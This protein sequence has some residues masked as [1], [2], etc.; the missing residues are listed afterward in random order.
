[1]KV[2]ITGISGFAGNFMYDFLTNIKDIDIYGMY[3]D[4]NRKNNIQKKFDKAKLWEIDMIN[5]TQ[6]LDNILKEV[7]PDIIMHFAAYVTVIGSFKNPGPIFQTNLIGTVNLLESVRKIIPE[8]KVLITGSAEEYGKVPNDKLP[9]KEEYSLNPV[10]PYALSKKFQEDIGL[11]YFNNYGVKVYFTR[12]FHTAGPKQ[13]IGYVCTDIAK[14][15]AEIEKG[16]AK[17][18][19]VGNLIAKRDFS[20]IRDVINAYWR[21]INYGKAGEIYNVCSGTS[22]SIQEILDRLIKYSNKTIK[23]EVDKDKLRPSDV[24]DFVGDNTNLKKIG[25][26]QKYTLEDTLSAVLNWWRKSI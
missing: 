13:P 1:M 22:V 17:S 23:V 16:N 9:I 6:L 11:Y 15:I 4:F 3:W 7:Q 5:D 19:Q 12:T 8:S 10:S 24:P 2:L 18:I 26:S 21:I 25:W 20:D 14:Q